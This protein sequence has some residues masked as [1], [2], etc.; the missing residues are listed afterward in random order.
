MYRALKDL[1]RRLY[2]AVR[3]SQ[4]KTLTIM[5]VPDAREEVRRIRISFFWLYTLAALLVVVSAVTAYI[6]FA[7]SGLQVSL[8]R[9]R[10]ERRREV[11]RNLQLQDENRRKDEALSRLYQEAKHLRDKMVQLEDLSLQVNALMQKV[12][13]PV[14]VRTPLPSRGGAVERSAD[15][16]G[17][18]AGWSGGDELLQQV[19]SELY[20]LR[21]EVPEQEER[22]V[23]LKSSL[24]EYHRRL[25]HTPSIWPVFGWI[26]SGF[27]YRIHPLTGE[28]EFHQGVDIAV[29][30]R[31]P[32]RAA[33]AG[34]VSWAGVRLGYG[35]T[36]IIE[37]GYGLRTLY[38]HNSALAVRPGQVVKK[39][40]VIA[41]S[42]SSG[43]TTGP[44]L[45]YEVYVNGKLVNPLRYLP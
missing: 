8:Y 11:A 7:S 45:H 33:G 27:G 43:R 35:L 41:Y 32:V 37:H 15:L 44:H 39:G 17:L 16:A 20:A 21:R 42:G 24:E 29:P 28:R 13:Q 6:Y 12:G 9:E 26:S 14:R 25:E 40:Q 22:L 34:T 31:T 4:R 23:A 36:I 3:Q 38:A 30:Y 10:V 2:L 1:S 19:Q 5:L 18:R